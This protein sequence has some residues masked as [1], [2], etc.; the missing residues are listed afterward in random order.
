MDKNLFYNN[1]NNQDITESANKVSKELQEGLSLFKDKN[2][3]IV[4]V[5]GS[6]RILD[7]SFFYNEAEEIGRYLAEAGYS[8]ITGGGP[9][10]MEAAA[11]GAYNKGGNTYGIVIDLPHEER[12]NPYSKNKFKCDNLFTRK[13]LLTGSHVDGFIVMPGGYGTLD[14]LFEILTLISTTISRKVPVVL[15]NKDFWGGLLDWI[16]ASLLRNG[17]IRQ[18]ELDNIKVTNNVKEAIKL[19]TGEK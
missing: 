2:E 13:V 3:K 6:S 14:E 4:A 10:V 15:I 8:V 16:S 11:K 19:V 9:G 5:F 17:F 12:S 1:E 7:D 18:E